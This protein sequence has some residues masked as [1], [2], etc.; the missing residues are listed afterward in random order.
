[1]KFICKV[2]LVCLGG[3]LYWQYGARANYWAFLSATSYS[4]C[5][6]K[7]QSII[8]GYTSS[9]SCPD[10]LIMGGSSGSSSGAGSSSGSSYSSGSG[11][12]CY[13]PWR[14]ARMF[15]S[16][17]NI[18]STFVSTEDPNASNSSKLYWSDVLVVGPG[19][20]TG[21]QNSCF[22]VTA[23]YAS[24]L[25]RAINS[26]TACANGLTSCV[27]SGCMASKT[28]GY[29]KIYIGGGTQSQVVP[30]DLS[31]QSGLYMPSATWASV[32]AN[33]KANCAANYY[34]ATSSNG[35]WV[36]KICELDSTK[37]PEYSA[38][39]ATSITSCY[40]P[41]S[42]SWSFTDTAGSGKEQFASNC[43]YSS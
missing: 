31:S 3:L 15:G 35:S 2:M 23:E 37:N 42:A 8:G 11:T 18:I 9:G 6:A 7:C 16:L 38:A 40:V 1:M 5:D 4:A 19:Y 30:A 33:C 25:Q 22:C 27:G 29:W 17:G 24:A 13:Y 41:S 21:I 43:Y 10:G 20:S 26:R 36:C 34:P 28:G 32:T 14:D 39:R 12:P